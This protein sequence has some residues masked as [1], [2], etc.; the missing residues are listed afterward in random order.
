MMSVVQE[1]KPTQRPDAAA[2]RAGQRDMWERIR[3]IWSWVSRIGLSAFGV[4]ALVTQFRMWE[5]G[6]AVT[7]EWGPFLVAVVGYA[8]LVW[9]RWPMPATLL[10]IGGY[11]GL[12]ALPGTFNSGLWFALLPFFILVN[13]RRPAWLGLVSSVIV[14]LGSLVDWAESPSSSVFLGIYAWSFTFLG[15]FIRSQA[16]AKRWQQEAHELQRIRERQALA[17]RMH[18][19][20]AAT[21]TQATALTRAVLI[22]GHVLGE[23]RQSLRVV[24]EDLSRGLDELRSIVRYLESGEPSSGQATEPLALLLARSQEA[25]SEAGFLVSISTSG[26]WTNAVDVGPVAGFVLAEATANVMKHAAPGGFVH[27]SAEVSDGSVFLA[28]M[29]QLAPGGGE[30]ARGEGLG[31]RSLA[32]RVAGVGGWFSAGPEDGAWALRATLPAQRWT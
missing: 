1:A 8:M 9:T 19:S 30:D 27:V 22:R 13:T 21:L 23:D 24:D 16:E 14:T 3:P 32:K 20:L 4:L 26:D 12:M 25:L 10:V 29:N 31:L 18:D 2:R 6:E 15:M 5:H 17:A 7:S 11:L 28:L